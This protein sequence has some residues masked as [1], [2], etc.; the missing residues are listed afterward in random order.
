MAL[1]GIDTLLVRASYTQ[2]PTESRCL[3]LGGRTSMGLGKGLCLRG[4]VPHSHLQ[5]V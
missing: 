3:E 1:A 4:T 2:Q 5:T